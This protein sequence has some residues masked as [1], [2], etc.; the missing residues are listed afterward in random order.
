L[1]FEEVNQKVEM[2]EDLH[3]TY[4][5]MKHSNIFQEVKNS[6]TPSIIHKQTKKFN[7]KAKW[8]EMKWRRR[9][10]RVWFKV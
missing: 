2:N 8:I 5:F 10:Y 6:K 4:P 3:L 1:A 7:K 9:I